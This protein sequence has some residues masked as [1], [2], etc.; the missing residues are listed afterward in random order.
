MGLKPCPKSAFGKRPLKS[1]LK[2]D[3]LEH[4]IASIKKWLLQKNS[5]VQGC[6]CFLTGISG[7]LPQGR[8]KLT[9]K[10]IFQLNALTDFLLLLN[11]ASTKH[12]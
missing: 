11:I 9:Q 7:G 4:E 8:D 12:V 10:N 5:G 1:L 2:V 6:K 3:E